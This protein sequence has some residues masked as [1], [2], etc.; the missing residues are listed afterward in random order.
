MRDIEF[1]RLLSKLQAGVAINNA[2]IISNPIPYIEEMSK[3]C[4][5]VLEVLDKVEEALSQVPVIEAAAKMGIEP[6]DLKG[7]ALIRCNKASKVISQ[8]KRGY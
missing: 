7:E 4:H 1:R 6:R 2:K 5:E 8:Y 3:R